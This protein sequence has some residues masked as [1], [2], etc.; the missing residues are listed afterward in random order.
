[1]EPVTEG[2]HVKLDWCLAPLF[3]Y[4]IRF[5]PFPFLL[6]LHSFKLRHAYG[7]SYSRT[8]HG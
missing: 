2:I 6:R 7:R 1:M 4:R 5:I 3:H 8:C